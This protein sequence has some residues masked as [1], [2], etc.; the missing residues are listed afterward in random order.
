MQLTTKRRDGYISILINGWNIWDI[1]EKEWTYAFQSAIIQA[2]E[3]GAR[4]ALDQSQ[5][6][7][8]QVRDN[9]Y[10]LGSEWEE[11]S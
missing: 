5:K 8:E 4:H 3:I 10:S 6:N 7:I 9:F 11:E 2:Y 1:P